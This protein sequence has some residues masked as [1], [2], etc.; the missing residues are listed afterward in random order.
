[1]ERR[2]GKVAV[3][4][5]AGYIGSVPRLREPRR[6]RRPGHTDARVGGLRARG[7]LRKAK[8]LDDEYVDV[9]LMGLFP[10]ETIS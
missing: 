4:G 2:A 5:G 1:M 10:D 6:R 8:Y 9:V 7:M 3:F